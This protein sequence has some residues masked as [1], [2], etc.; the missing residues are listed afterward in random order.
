MATIFPFGLEDNHELLNIVNTDSIKSLDYLPSYEIV[1]KAHNIE[2]LNQFDVDANIIN[3]ITSLN[4]TLPMSSKL[5]RNRNLS[6]SF[7]LI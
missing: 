4:I 6:L 7:T 2:A 1:S 3:K 5:S